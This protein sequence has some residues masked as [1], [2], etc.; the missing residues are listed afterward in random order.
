MGSGSDFVVASGFLM[1]PPF[2]GYTHA[3]YATSTDYYT[4][5]QPLY[6]PLKLPKTTDVVRDFSSTSNFRFGGSQGQRG[7][8]KINEMSCRNF[9]I[10]AGHQMSLNPNTLNIIRAAETITIG[11][12]GV[13]SSNPSSPYADT[14]FGGVLL[15]YPYDHSSDSPA[16]SAAVGKSGGGPTATN[17]AGG[18]PQ[19]DTN[20]PSSRD[21]A[22]GAPAGFTA[23]AAGGNAGATCRTALILIAKNIVI[24]GNITLNGSNATASTNGGHGGGHGGYLDLVAKSITYTGGTMNVSGGNGANGSGANSGG[25]G[26][27]HCGLIRALAATFSGSGTILSA[28]PGTGGTKTGTAFNGADGGYPYPQFGTGYLQY[29][30]NPF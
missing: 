29:T 5:K 23:N 18:Q 25:G 12:N 15:D 28:S 13:I 26:G 27:G 22:V 19:L 20:N 17:A 14:N 8:V 3:N 10:N 11:G 1:V 2:Q 30:G 7:Y 6:I 21:P 24:N 4:T 9:T 16:G